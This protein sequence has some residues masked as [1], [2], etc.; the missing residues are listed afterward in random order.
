MMARALGDVDPL[1]YCESAV[2]R[3]R[4]LPEPRTVA[5]EH[6]EQSRDLGCSCGRAR[7]REVCDGTSAG[8]LRWAGRT[9]EDSGRLHRDPREE[10]AATTGSADLW[11]DRT[12]A[13]GTEGLAGGQR[14]YPR[15]D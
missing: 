14:R 11:N 8:A 12:G 3:T 7:T 1:W 15:S 13:S 6:A 2:K 10:G 4:E 5:F 9:Q